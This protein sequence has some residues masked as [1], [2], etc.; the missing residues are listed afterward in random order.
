[1]LK[2]LEIEIPVNGVV[3]KSN[4]YIFRRREFAGFLNYVEEGSVKLIRINQEGREVITHI[5]RKG[6]FFSEA[7]LFEER[8]HCDAIALENSI[9]RKYPK[10]E[11]LSFISSNKEAALS[12]IRVLSKNIQSL[13]RQ[14]EIV[15]TLSAKE[16]VWLYITTN[17]ENGV[18]EIPGPLKNLASQV[19][20]AH[21]TLYR[22]LSALE[23]EGWIVKGEKEI[24]VLRV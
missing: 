15:N 7:A 17:A 14:L 12:F 6:E 11:V 19:G 5:A 21:E 10:D 3:F 22:Q 24:K 4:S 8:Y 18:L 16:K 1:M 13:R 2:F 20:L 23:E 9:I